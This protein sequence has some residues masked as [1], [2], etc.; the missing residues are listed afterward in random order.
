[1]PLRR[2]GLL[3]FFL[4]FFFKGLAL[5]VKQT[6]FCCPYAT[7]WGSTSFLKMLVKTCTQGTGVSQRCPAHVYP[8]S[9]SAVE[10]VWNRLDV[11]VSQLGR[12][13]ALITAS[14]WP[15]ILR[16]CCGVESVSRMGQA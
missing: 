7:L 8:T 10:M 3:S 1:M 2:L 15:P 14:S 5:K 12:P 13:E 11:E 6:T 4:F 9:T 16:G